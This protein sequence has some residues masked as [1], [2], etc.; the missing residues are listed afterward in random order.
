MESKG[1]GLS[2]FNELFAVTNLLD[3]EMH[4]EKTTILYKKYRNISM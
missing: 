3:Q 2:L 4:H 1:S